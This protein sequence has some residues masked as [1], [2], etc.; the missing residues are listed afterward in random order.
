M[1]EWESLLQPEERDVAMLIDVIEHMGKDDG[2]ALLQGL[3]GAFR[4]IL[5]MTPDGFIP[6]D[7]DVTGYENEWQ[8]HECGWVQS[9]LEAEG[10][11]VEVHENFHVQL[12][13]NALFATWERQ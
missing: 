1:R 4:K 7:S 13:R 12:Q 3:Q 2:V 8:V 9:E 5:V 10:F 6:Q 11:S